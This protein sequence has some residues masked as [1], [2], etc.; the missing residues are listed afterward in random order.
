M[1]AK[2][3]GR[4]LVDRIEVEVVRPAPPRTPEEAAARV[5][6]EAAIRESLVQILADML[7]RSLREEWAAEAR[8][9]APP[10]EGAVGSAPAIGPD[11]AGQHAGKSG[12]ILGAPAGVLSEADAA[13]YIGLSR[14]FLKKRRR[15]GKPP[16]YL[17]LGRGI[18][19]AVADLDALLR[20]A[21]VEPRGTRGRP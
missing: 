20:D 21:R 5:Q 4:R 19:Y 8:A 7:V 6:K 14:A 17:R 15:E 13:R 11:G 2:A 18:R 10:V 16:A 1:G 12:A 3:R 9:K